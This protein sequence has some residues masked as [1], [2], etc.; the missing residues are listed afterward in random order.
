MTDNDRYCNL[1]AIIISM[2]KEGNW[3]CKELFTRKDQ[4]IKTDL[5][6]VIGT[7]LIK[8]DDLEQKLKSTN[9]V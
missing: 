9:N 3:D 1:L 6:K 8:I 4:F 5:I 2:R 7:L